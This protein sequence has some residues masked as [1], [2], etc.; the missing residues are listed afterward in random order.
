MREVVSE[1]DSVGVLE[2]QHNNTAYQ[3]KWRQE[4][5]IQKRMGPCEEKLDDRSGPL[6]SY[7][8]LT[9]KGHSSLIDLSLQRDKDNS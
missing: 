4:A 6:V 1:C 5:G 7:L 9:L 3:R 8:A 2:H